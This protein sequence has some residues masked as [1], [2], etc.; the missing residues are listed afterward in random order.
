MEAV[1]IAT[2]GG[3][4]AQLAQAVDVAGD[5][6]ERL[7]DA[8]PVGRNRETRVTGEEAFADVQ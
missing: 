3:E 4:A 7:L 8:A 1:A 2:F 6:A 5:K